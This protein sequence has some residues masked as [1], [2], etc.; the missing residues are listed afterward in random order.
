MRRA[1]LPLIAIAL[2]GSEADLATATQLVGAIPG[3]CASDGFWVVS[4]VESRP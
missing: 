1:T 2:G 4:T 3:A